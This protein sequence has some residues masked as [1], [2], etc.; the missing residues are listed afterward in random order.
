MFRRT[1][2]ALALL[3]VAGC[4]KCSRSIEQSTSSESSSSN[5]K[6]STA[7]ASKKAPPLAVKVGPDR[8][9]LISS[10]AF[11]TIDG[12]DR[13]V[14]STATTRG[15]CA[16]PNPSYDGET[17]DFVDVTIELP[18][19]RGYFGA[20]VPVDVQMFVHKKGSEALPFSLPMRHAILTLDEGKFEAGGTLGGR[21]EIDDAST[22]DKVTVDGRFA[23]PI[24]DSVKEYGG[25][26]LPSKVDGPAQVKG[27]D[28]PF[29]VRSTLVMISDSEGEPHVESI[30]FHSQEATC[31]TDFPKAKHALAFG[32]PLPVKGKTTG[33]AVPGFNFWFSNDLAPAMKDVRIAQSWVRFDALRLEK[34]TKAKGSVALSISRAN[35]EPLVLNGTFE[36]TVCPF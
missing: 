32:V 22:N 18:I 12:A 4:A 20:P 9:E 17:N 10:C 26:K 29:A 15:T 31:D 19:G 27:I 25:P 13:L 24:D 36:A 30:I 7:P 1:L 16:D 8:Y 21:L 2:V 11:S 35:D 3:P 34:G 6:P 23:A 33:L 14:F 28:D 5:S